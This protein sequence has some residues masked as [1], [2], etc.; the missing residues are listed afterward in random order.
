M[1]DIRHYGI[2]HQKTIPDVYKVNAWG[3]S[4][5]DAIGVNQFSAAFW[6]Q[7]FTVDYSSWDT[8]PSSYM[9]S[10]L[11]HEVGHQ[12]DNIWGSISALPASNFKTAINTDKGLINGM[13]CTAVFTSARCN[14]PKAI[15]GTYTSIFAAILNVD[16]LPCSQVLAAA[17]CSGP[18]AGS[19]TAKFTAIANVDT[20]QCNAVF[21]TTRCDS[22]R[23]TN[24]EI[25]DVIYDSAPYE[26]W[27]MG[28]QAAAGGTKPAEFITIMNKL[29]NLKNYMTVNPNIM[30]N[31]QPSNP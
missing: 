24:W 9:A 19:N 27:A 30:Q 29:T 10:T 14:A 20:L 17:I 26:L 28:I 8:A 12:L 11:V 16:T 23:K 13:G 18:P 6:R 3:F 25:L 15:N 21:A 31:G 1:R 5:L 2:F 4:T 22:N 7:F